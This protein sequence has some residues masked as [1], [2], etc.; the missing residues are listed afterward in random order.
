MKTNENLVNWQSISATELEKLIRF[1]LEALWTVDSMMLG[2]DNEYRKIAE[3]IPPMMIWGPPGIG[4]SSIVRSIANDFGINFIDIRLAQREPIDIRGL[5]V[6]ENDGVHWVISAEWPRDPDSKG[7]ILFDEL[8]SADRTLQVAAYE[9]ILDRRLGDLYTV[10]DG[11]YIMAAGNRAGDKAVA[12]TM[13][14]ALA[15]RFMHVELEAEVESWVKWAMRN[16]IHP[17]VIA[18]IRFKPGS[19]F[20]MEGNLE[21]GWPTPRSW[22]RVS[23]MLHLNKDFQELKGD[24]FNHVIEGLV[25]LG[26]GAEFESFREWNDKMEDVREL[27]LDPNK[28]IN[29]PN[30]ADVKYAICSSLVYNLWRAENEEIQQKLIDGFFRISFQLSSD[31]AAMAMVDAMLGRNH[32]DAEKYSTLLYNN[33]HYKKWQ[34][35]HGEALK[36]T[37]NQYGSSNS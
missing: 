8:T 5:P 31:F 6:P 23:T 25:G 30:K 37:I 11:W 35:K 10:P 22:E 2:G 3:L 1:Q 7:I 32:K 13:S 19:F 20:N 34:A 27:M 17:D 36:K 28:E 21:K 29:I 26:A 15:N 4:K 12:T 33:K 9:F 18:F 14:S 16:N 24:L